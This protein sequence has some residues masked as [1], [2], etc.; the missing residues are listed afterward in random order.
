MEVILLE[1]VAK[2]GQMGELVRVKD[3]FARNFLLPRGKALRATAA[4]RD[5][6]E[7]MK[8]D[9]EARNIEAKAEAAKVAEK[10]D[11]K[12]VIVI[13]QASETGQ[14]F[15]SVSVRDIVT[16]FEADGV[17][18]TRSQILLDAPIKTIGRHTIEVAVHPE[19]EVGVSVTVARSVEEAERINRG[20]DISSRREDQDA[21]A[22]AIAAA[23]EFFDPDA[24][25][26][27]EPEQQ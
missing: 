15:G 12:N 2:L 26:D 7:H 14:L 17:K 19:V 1:R 5:K 6:Y 10:I 24:Q 16:S 3:G 13:R 8:A 25:Q 27:E 22:E 21:A 4:N 18:I 11:G 20:E 23:G 9:L